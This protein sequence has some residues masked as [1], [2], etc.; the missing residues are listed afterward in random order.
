M[1]I[2]SQFILTMGIFGI[3]LLIIAL[4]V[5]LTNE[6]LGRLKNQEDIAINIERQASELSYFSND[7]LLYREDQQ[8]ARWEA[9]WISLYNDVSKLEPDTPEEQVL[10][11]NIKTNHHHLK[12]VFDNVAS[13]FQDKDRIIADSLQSITQV[14][15][16]RIAVQNQGIISDALQ[17]SQV[18]RDRKDKLMRMN[19]LLIS[20]LL[21]AF[22]AYLLATYLIVQ[23]RLLRSVAALQAGI[24]V[25][26][27]GNLDFQISVTRDD[28]IGDLSHSFNKMTYDLKSVTASKSELEEEVAERRQA[29]KELLEAKQDQER[30][31]AQLQAILDHLTE[32]LVVA[33]LDANLF[34]W[35]PAAVSMHGFSE[36]QG[37]KLKLMEFADIFELS[38]EEDGILPLNQWPL[39]RIL[40]GEILQ[41]WEVRIRRHGT[42]WQRTFSYGGTL[43]R[44]TE[45][46]PVLAIITITDITERKKT[47]EHIKELNENLK[48]KN[49]ELASANRELESFS[50]SV[51][52]D[53]R[54]PLRHITGFSEL[55]LKRSAADLDEK[56]R[57]YL[58]VIST[59]ALQMGRL[60]DD[61]LEFSRTGRVEVKKQL[62]DM[63]LVLKEVI[64]TFSFE[65]KER[66]IEWNISPLRNAYGDPGLLKLVWTNLISNALKFTRPSG[67]AL[68]EIKR[69]DHADE[70]VF[71]IKDNGVGFDM[72]YA[73]K[74]FGIFQRMH[75]LDEFEGT[76]IGLAGVQRIIH[77]HGGRIW[78]EAAP[79]HGAT[80]F[81]SLP[82]SSK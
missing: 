44:N 3:V 15:W 22:S 67:R 59:G 55:L 27:S 65:T 70:Q 47:E 10:V 75:R 21:I 19:S 81:F 33:D 54:A 42:D 76:G 4:S 49:A 64:N 23:R 77:R 26:G 53:L 29:E 13:V 48:K 43:A 63:D 45:G 20:G 25:V 5:A 72:K 56:S 38:T 57:H 79:G 68:I 40:R 69:Y 14:S 12:G 28:E 36:G 41:Q 18:I 71:S 30:H 50:Y 74:L 9:K 7:Y 82:E 11:D 78:A 6:Q 1:R 8:F 58:D 52:H 34:H 16:S 24:K 32:G 51:S 73:D 60:I 46:K 31:S 37:Y 39:A 62:F 66:D 35:N 80:F 2:R 61:L 17:L